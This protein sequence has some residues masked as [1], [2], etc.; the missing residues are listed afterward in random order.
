MSNGLS[1]H[2]DAAQTKFVDRKFCQY[3]FC[4]IFI[5]IAAQ[6]ARL[7]YI[8]IYIYIYIISVI[9]DY[10]SIPSIVN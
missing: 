3:I 5:G 7:L 8:Y 9:L 6:F 4:S 2:D 10:S 1:R